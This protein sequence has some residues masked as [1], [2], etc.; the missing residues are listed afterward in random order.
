MFTQLGKSSLFKALLLAISA[1]LSF[2]IAVLLKV[3]N[4][5][6][7]AMPVWVIAQSTRGLLFER[8]LYRVVGTLLGAGAGLLILMT[9]QP[10]WELFLMAVVIFICAGALHILQGVRGYIAL[11]S[12]ITVAVVVLPALLAPE[13]ALELAWA[14]I[15]ST[16]IG[17]VI[18]TIITSIGTPPS[19]RQQFYQQVRQLAA[20]AVQTTVLLLT[21]Q[22]P[23]K[24]NSMLRELSIRLS[25]LEAQAANTA[26]G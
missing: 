8:A 7:A 5:Y 17:V 21:E 11:L 10:L 20:D 16:L 19:P 1:W 6:W 23:Q 2:L 13:Q 22:Q 26:A 24:I 9:N 18:G 15:E 4:P 14:R 25:D 3:D 12:G